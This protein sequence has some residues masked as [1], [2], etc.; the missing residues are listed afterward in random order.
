MNNI[1]TRLLFVSRDVTGGGTEKRLFALARSLDTQ[2]FR[3]RVILLSSS[4]RVIAVN[5]DISVAN[6]RSFPFRSPRFIGTLRAMRA[7]IVTFRPHAIIST[8]R[9]EILTVSIASAGL[10][11]PQI[12]Q[13]VNLSDDF[14]RPIFRSVLGLL[15]PRVGAIIANSEAGAQVARSSFSRILTEADSLIRV[16]PNGVD[17]AYYRPP[18]E[19]EKRSARASLGIDD[20][21]ICFVCVANLKTLKRLD[22][23][24]CAAAELQH[25]VPA[26]LLF[27]GEGNERRRLE[28]MAGELGL[29]EKTT[30]CGFQED[31]RRFLWAADVS[32]L[33]SR[34]E[35][36]SNAILESMSCGLPVVASAVG[37]NIESVSADRGFLFQTE[38]FEEFLDC[39]RMA[40][41]RQARER[42]GAAA[43]KWI[44]KRR[45][46]SDTIEQYEDTFEVVA[47]R[48]GVT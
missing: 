28:T 24:L 35:G 8:F 20:A 10:G 19:I 39:L 6:V 14:Q 40:A 48:R 23:L 25:D 27:V 9:D 3:P 16:I 46:H 13:K 17:T 36:C 30:F 7:E 34:S 5:S 18:S 42:V 12:I 38:S 41:C 43:R 11:V 2:R 29:R 31:V 15:P 1:A 26:Y 32:V 22:W 44:V 37:G 4:P 33:C 21:D 45:S 47:N